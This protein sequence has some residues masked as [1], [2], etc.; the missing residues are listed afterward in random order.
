[1]QTTVRRMEEDGSFRES[2]DLAACS[3]EV[4]LNYKGQL[5][6]SV[7]LAYE[8]GDGSMALDEMQ[9]MTDRLE[10]MYAGR[11]AEPVTGKP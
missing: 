9:R 6:Y 5:Q 10:E 3:V 1:M 2:V 7:K 4:T 11:L 8:V